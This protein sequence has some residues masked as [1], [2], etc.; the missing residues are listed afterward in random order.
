MVKKSEKKKNKSSAS[1][2]V[3]ASGEHVLI[4]A[5]PYYEKIT[6]HLFIGATAVL[7]ENACT[8]DRVDVPGALE[9]PQALR[10]A[11]EAGLIGGAAK[12]RYAGAL[13]LGCVIRGETSHYDIVCN[14]ANHWLMESVIH[15]TIPF[16]NAILT[17]D[18]EAQA[19]ARAKGGASGKGGDAARACLSL[20]WQRERFKALK[21]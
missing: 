15:H 17:V 1:D 11:V 4:I 19:L 14:N 6:N 5:S 3:L 8:F 9:I 2:I 18:T 7:S 20:I 13:A 10:Q 21:P 12:T 16:G